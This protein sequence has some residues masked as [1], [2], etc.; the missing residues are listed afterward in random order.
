MLR[1]WKVLSL[2]QKQAPV[3]NENFRRCQVG[4]GVEIR[5]TRSISYRGKPQFPLRSRLQLLSVNCLNDVALITGAYVA[6]HR[7]TRPTINEFTF[8]YVTRGEMDM[9]I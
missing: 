7:E 1:E 9:V 8:S 5:S 4:R 6:H 3:R 2:S